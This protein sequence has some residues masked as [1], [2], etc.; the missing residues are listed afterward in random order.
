M[1]CV[2]PRRRA[3][4]RALNTSASLDDLARAVGIRI[5]YTTELEGKFR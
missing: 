5:A 2:F 3:G 4:S 1:K